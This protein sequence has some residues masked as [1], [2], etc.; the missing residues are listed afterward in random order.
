MN[1]NLH[2]IKEFINSG[3]S[4]VGKK[5][6]IIIKNK[7]QPINILWG[8]K[9]NKHFDFVDLFFISKLIKLS[10]HNCHIYIL[11][12]DIHT[13]IDESFKQHETIIT[14][15]YIQQLEKI[16]KRFIH[17]DKITILK[18]SDFQ[19]DKNYILDTYNILTNYNIQ[20]L[21]HDLNIDT[22]KN[23]FKS[24]L[25]PL[26]QSLDE[27]YILKIYNIDIDMSIG[28]EYQYK[29]YTFSK[30]INGRLNYKKRFY[31]LF[32]IPN[33][34]IEKRLALFQDKSYYHNNL[35][36]YNIK[37]LEF[38]ENMLREINMHLEIT[39]IDFFN[40][41]DTLSDNERNDITINKIIDFLTLL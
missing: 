34:L 20:E 7:T 21:C 3:E 36:C 4:C 6:P 31:C 27:Q 13:L 16:I 25:H 8:L 40:I 1:E 19:L 12:A 39:S 17:L 5:K 41:D 11:I 23:N 10:N 37:S 26:L 28:M 15:K 35:R 22:A 29:Y 32:Y 24:I 18:G 38:I 33:E 2:N 14:E 9:I 30:K